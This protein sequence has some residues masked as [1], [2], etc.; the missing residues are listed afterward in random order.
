MIIPSRWFAGGRGL[1]E[2]RDEMLHDTH[3]RT[4]VDYP[5]SSECFPGVEI[6]GGVCYFLWNRDNTGF[7]KVITRRNSSESISTRSLLEEG[8][9][10]FIRYNESS[11]R[12]LCYRR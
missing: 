3:I 8:S 10:T 1:D 6:K 9:D 12:S 5:L 2:F 7:C 11:E 4:I